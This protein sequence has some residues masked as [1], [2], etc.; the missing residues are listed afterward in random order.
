[1]M[2]NQE[3]LEGMIRVLEKLRENATV[4]KFQ[5]LQNAAIRTDLTPDY[6]EQV[7]TRLDTPTLML[8]H[9]AMGLHTESGELMDVLK[10]WLFYGKP[11][12]RVSMFEEGGDIS[13]YLRLLAESLKDLAEGKCAF[14]EMLDRNVAKLKAR[15]P[16]KF[17]EE[18]ALNR[19]LVTERQVLEG[20]SDQQCQ[21]A[22]NYAAATVAEQNDPTTRHTIVM[23]KWDIYDSEGV[24]HRQI[25]APT[26]K[27]ACDMHFLTNA[28]Y[29][30]TTSTFYGFKLYATMEEVLK[31]APKEPK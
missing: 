3:E 30:S 9:A 16:D 6:Y 14:E 20:Q 23:K 7:K 13:W 18:L 29:N 28:G 24:L 22:E 4:N 1:M 27:D 15:F 11:I 19:D 2:F 10:R 21:Q 12:D 25:E 8:L 17:S 26:F 5:Q 31:N